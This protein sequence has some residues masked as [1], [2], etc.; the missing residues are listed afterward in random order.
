MSLRTHY[1][2]DKMTTRSSSF[3]LLRTARG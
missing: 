1:E 2:V 3:T